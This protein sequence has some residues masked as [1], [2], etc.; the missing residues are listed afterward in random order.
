MPHVLAMQRTGTTLSRYYVVDSLCCP[1]RSAIF[2]GEYPHDD[3]VFTN[4]GR[5]GGY[6]AYNAHGDQSRSFAVALQNAGYQTAMMGKYLNLYVP[7]RDPPAPG[8]NVW[9][10]TGN[11]YPEFNYQLNEN[12]GS[13]VTATRHG[14]T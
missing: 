5:D 3:G 12:G 11:G 8:W 10:V 9:D 14:T 7:T 4:S 6:N 2:T 1:S 13:S